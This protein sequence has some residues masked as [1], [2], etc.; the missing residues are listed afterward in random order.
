MKQIIFNDLL[1]R[2]WAHLY[3][4]KKKI[5]TTYHD[6]D[7]EIITMRRVEVFI[8]CAWIIIHS[9]AT[10]QEK[11]KSQSEKKRRIGKSFVVNVSGKY[12]NIREAWL[13]TWL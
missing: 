4:K 13:D 1:H 9:E 5:R 6:Y 10:S 3:K 7:L 8:G 2:C 12:G 11:E